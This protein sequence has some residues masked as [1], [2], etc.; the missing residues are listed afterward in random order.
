MALN[1]SY[2]NRLDEKQQ[3]LIDGFCTS[4]KAEYNR[5]DH[6]IRNYRLDIEAYLHWCNH[7]TV[8]VVSVHHQQVRR[9]LA[10][11]DQ[12]GY[13]RT[14]I[15]RHLSSVK[16]FYRWLVVEGYCESNPADILHG[17]K[18][19]KSLPR[20]IAPH[21]ME[22]LLEPQVYEVNQT[23]GD[24]TSGSYK[25]KNRSVQDQLKT[26]ASTLSADH[27]PK[28]HNTSGISNRRHEALA[29]RNQALLELLYAAGIRVSEAS[30]LQM[31]GID[32]TQG[33][34][35]VMGKG[36]KER[37]I[38][39]H[40]KA[41]DLLRHYIHDARPLLLGNTSSS[42]VFLSS[43]GNPLS[44]NTIRRVFKEALHQAGLDESL[45]PHA[46]RHSFATDLLS[47]GA[48]LRSVQEMLGHASLST[49][50]I[51]THLSP[52]RLK[53]VHHQSHPRG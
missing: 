16:G 19:V 21:D 28:P 8:D 10:Y 51:Y 33:L 29:L 39:I 43:R 47:G 24:L 37:V 36:S 9:Y 23:E 32:Y 17:P 1:D 4:L 42:Y 49:T 26:S 53:A 46:V 27:L 31:S 15:N 52:D 12:A 6:T 30:S 41:C 7:E 22:R 44:T 18:Q 5:S 34:V 13:A 45:S 50:Q 2:D 11:L 25:K 20:V 48:D 35:R 3:S 14:T 38:P 40:Q